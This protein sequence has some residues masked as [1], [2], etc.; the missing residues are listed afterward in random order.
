MSYNN[1][2]DE[3]LDIIQISTNW[4]DEHVIKQTR[5][6]A[7]IIKPKIIKPKL[8]LKNIYQAKSKVQTPHEKYLEK[9]SQQQLVEQS[10]KELIEL[11]FK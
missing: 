11:L 5:V 6:Q 3:D 1:P 4:D 2:I 7:K 10:D 9:Y 8:N